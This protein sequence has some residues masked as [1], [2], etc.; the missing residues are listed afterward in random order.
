MKTRVA[1]II[2]IVGTFATPAAAAAETEAF[3]PHVFKSELSCPEQTHLMLHHTES[4]SEEYCIDREN[5]KHGYYLRWHAG[6]GWAELGHYAAGVK[7]GRWAEFLEDGRLSAVMYFKHG[8]RYLP[9]KDH[10][11]RVMVAQS[12]IVR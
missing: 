9:W 2:A 8:I 5:R 10:E 7:D 4:G 3:R 12:S 1:A 11:P 6:A